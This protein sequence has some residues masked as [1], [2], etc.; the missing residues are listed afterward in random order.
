MSGMDNFAPDEPQQF[1]PGLWE[2]TE[3]EM[4]MHLANLGVRDEDANVIVDDLISR[5]AHIAPIVPIGANAQFYAAYA[6]LTCDAVSAAQRL[7]A[8]QHGRM[9]GALLDEWP[10]TTVT[11]FKHPLLVAFEHVVGQIE[12]EVGNVAP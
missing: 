5:L 3:F 12:A 2:H 10:A 1:V 4:L 7:F 11:G 6:A 9:P 8:G